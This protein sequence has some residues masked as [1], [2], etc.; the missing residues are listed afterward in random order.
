ML[1]YNNLI[2]MLFTLALLNNFS[3]NAYASSVVHEEH[4]EEIELG[5]GQ[6]NIHLLSGIKRTSEVDLQDQD[7]GQKMIFSPVGL[8]SLGIDFTLNVLGA[9]A[10]FWGATDVFSLRDESNNDQFRI[11][12][13]AIG[14]VA[15]TRYI[16]IN[17]F[18]SKKYTDY[19]QEYRP[20]TIGRKLVKTIEE[21][22]HAL[23]ATASQIG[24]KLFFRG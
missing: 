8:V 10:A 16:V 18:N 14:A 7:T 4:H 21:P 17:A 13:M 2:K 23:R 19:L 20:A 15:V 3:I 6:H 11:A 1:N 5:R 9:P 12:A 24:S 22:F